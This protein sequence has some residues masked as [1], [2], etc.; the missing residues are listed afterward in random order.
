[1]RKVKSVKRS[2]LITI[3]VSTIAT[4]CLAQSRNRKGKLTV[5][6]SYETTYMNLVKKPYRVYFIIDSSKHISYKKHQFYQFTFSNDTTDTSGF[7][8]LNKARKTLDF[9]VS[10]F[11]SKN[12]FCESGVVQSVFL[13]ANGKTKNICS[14]GILGSN[15]NLVSKSTAGKFKF[16]SIIN[17]SIKPPS[18]DRVIK[19]LLF[20]NN[21]FPDL[22]LIEDPVLMKIVEV[23][24]KVK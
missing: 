1:M 23:K 9:I 21:V 22:I 18:E 12:P 4:C 13:F 19:E 10:D 15:I 3:L 8:R 14:F 2:V 7:V 24:A 5:E 20:D 17:R 11:K 16:K 6:Y